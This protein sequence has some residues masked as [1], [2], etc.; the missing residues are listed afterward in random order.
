ME[1]TRRFLASISFLPTGAARPRAVLK[2]IIL[3]CPNMAARP[4]RTE[5]AKLKRLACWNADGV[6]SRKLELEHFVNQHCVDIFS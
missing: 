3:F 2:T 5:W 6:R 4:S 1:L